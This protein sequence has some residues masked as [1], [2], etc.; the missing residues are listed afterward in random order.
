MA[1]ITETEALARTLINTHNLLGWRF[2]WDNAR[3][4]GGQ[5]CYSARTIS[6]SRAL[7]PLWT[8]DQVRN[9][10]LHEIAHALVGPGHGHD[11]VWMYKC[12]SIGGDGNRT[13][14]N[15]TQARKWEAHCDT[16]GTVVGRR[17]RLT[18]AMRDHAIHPVCKSR[19]RWV[20]TT[21]VGV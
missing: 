15:P 19:V 1:T 6:L 11:G 17:H 13:H 9:V 18:Q 14:N 16:C 21:L 7:V 12:L 20:D 5:C 10:L 8:E 4:R 3:S 2:V